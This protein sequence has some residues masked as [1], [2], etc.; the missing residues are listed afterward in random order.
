MSKTPL[1]INIVRKGEQKHVHRKLPRG[2]N[3]LSYAYRAL[4]DHRL[5]GQFQAYLIEFQGGIKEEIPLVSHEGEEFIYLLEGEVEF[6]SPK[7]SFTL[8]PG[9]SLHF[10]ASIPHGFVNQNRKIAKAIGIVSQ[11]P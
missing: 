10:D 2:K 3:P 7:E 8:K 11:K 6:R 9:D 1:N 5:A 4:S